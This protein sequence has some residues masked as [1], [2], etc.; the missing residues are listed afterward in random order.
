MSKHEYFYKNR[1]NI[2][3]IN[4]SLYIFLTFF[5]FSYFFV[6]I[7][8]IYIYIL[9]QIL[10]IQKEQKEFEANKKLQDQ[11]IVNEINEK[12]KNEKELHSLQ[13][14]YL[15]KVSYALNIVINTR[16]LTFSP[17]EFISLSYVRS[18]L[19]RGYGINE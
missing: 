18:I 13:L 15:F 12:V 4:P 17:S 8:Y 14:Q 19:L 11:R 6:I 9:Y 7:F 5:L 16:K 1:I 3:N 10:L 2:N